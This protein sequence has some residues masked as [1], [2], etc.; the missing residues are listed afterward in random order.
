MDPLQNPG[1]VLLLITYGLNVGVY[2]AV[3]SLL[4]VMILKHFK[5]AQEDAGRIGLVMEV[6]G[7]AGSMICGF[8]LDKT[9]QYKVTTL[10][11]QFLFITGLVLYAFSLHFGQIELVYLCAG[12]LGFFMTGYLPVGFDFGVEITFPESEG[13]TSGLLNASAQVFGIACTTA[14][15]IVV[16]KLNDGLIANCVLAGVLVIG[17]ILTTLIKPDYRRQRATVLHQTENN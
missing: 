16:T 15:E 12:L 10:A 4:N 7:M 14:V 11:I 2:Y 17:V 3:D 1:F 6:C 9:H 13:T 5:D 8:I